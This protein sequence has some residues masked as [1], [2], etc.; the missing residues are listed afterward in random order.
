VH[1]L[2]VK[3]A[4]AG[5][6]GY[7]GIEIFWEDLVFAAK[8]FDREA[9]EESIEPILQAAKWTKDLC[10][11]NGL[12]VLVLQPFMNY[13]GVLEPAMHAKHIAKLHLFFKVV[14]YWEQIPYR[15]PLR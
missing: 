1:E 12:E 6:A 4:A 3:L 5:K 11:Q 2:D 7:Q 13:D 9:T 15:F 10:N 8:R 14:K